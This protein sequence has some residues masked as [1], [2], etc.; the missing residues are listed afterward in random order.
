METCHP[1]STSLLCSDL[2]ACRV[3]LAKTLSGSPCPLLRVM[4]MTLNELQ[5]PL[6][7]RGIGNTMTPPRGA[8]VFSLG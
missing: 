6:E 3:T 4:A 7:A 2:P 1:V 8:D 5:S